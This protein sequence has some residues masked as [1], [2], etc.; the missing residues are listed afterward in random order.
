M[1]ARRIMLIILTLTLAMSACLVH[2]QQDEKEALRKRFEARDPA[3]QQLKNQ[4]K[5][6]ETYL[7]YLELRPGQSLDEQTQAT[8]DQENTDRRRLY[9]IIAKEQNTAA[10]NVGRRAAQRNFA[11]AATGHWLKGEREGWYQKK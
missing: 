9:Q 2:A 5:V 3:V 7:G 4:G 1:N 10:E 11:R 8:F 6:G